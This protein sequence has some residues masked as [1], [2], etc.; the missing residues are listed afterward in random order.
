MARLLD[1]RCESKRDVCVNSHSPWQAC[2]AGTHSGGPVQLYGTSRLV[3][4][5]LLI[6]LSACGE[7]RT[8]A[9]ESASG[10]H[11]TAFRLAMLSLGTQHTCGLTHEGEAYC[12]G[13]NNNGQ[14]GDGSTTN[15]SVPVEVIGGL[16][17]KTLEAGGSQTCGVATDGATYCWGYIYRAPGDDTPSIQPFPQRLLGDPA[18]ANLSFAAAVSCG[19]TAQGRAHCWGNHGQGQFGNAQGLVSGACSRAHCWK[20]VPA[21]PGWNFRALAPGSFHTCGLILDGDV[22]CWGTN[23]FGQVGDGTVENRPIPVRVAS[24]LR[25]ADLSGGLSYSC[26][27]TADGLAYCWGILPWGDAERSSRASRQNKLNLP[28]RPA[29]ISDQTRRFRN[30]AVGY[31]VACGLADSGV[32]ECWGDNDYGQL[33]QGIMGGPHR[34]SPRSITGGER[35]RYVA[36]GYR[37]AC[38]LSMNGEAHCWGENDKGQ[39]GDGSVLNRSMPVAVRR[40]QLRPQH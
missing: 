25:F 33:G 14:L 39:L 21:A 19:V 28:S 15:R 22:L 23:S 4:F 16:T 34:M 8:P 26:A 13:L 36:A 10:D 20:P 9:P 17:F 2:C 7:S 3:A 6:V 1:S 32:V 38:G 18:F 31:E 29:A 35:F 37:R 27:L 40:P 24:D 30:V 11:G 12:W 5:S